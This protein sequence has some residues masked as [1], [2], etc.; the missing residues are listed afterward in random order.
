MFGR[1]PRIALDV[2]LDLV[3]P[4]EPRGYGTYVSDLKSS[5]NEAYKLAQSKSD[6]SQLHQKTEYDKKIC[7]AV[8]EVGNRILVKKLAFD[9]KHKLADKWETAPY[10]VLSK[11]NPDIPV[12]DVQLEDGSGRVRTLHRNHLLPIG[13]L[14]LDV[15]LEEEKT[16]DHDDNIVSIEAESQMEEPNTE[17]EEYEITITLPGG[18]SAATEPQQEE[19]AVP[20]PTQQHEQPDVRPRVTPPIPQP[21]RSTRTRRKPQWLQSGDYVLMQAGT[22]SCDW[23]KS[24]LNKLMYKGILTYSDV[25]SM[26]K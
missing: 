1:K 15:R 24:M 18:Q 9:G 8:I 17:D 14:P 23:R 6:R 5:L 7:G 11:P 12:F 2:T 4:Q 13:E 3:T 26:C 16:P 19:I 25:Q 22:C 21:R 20:R 10:V